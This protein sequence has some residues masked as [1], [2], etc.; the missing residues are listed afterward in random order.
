MSESFQVVPS[1]AALAAE[2]RGLD[3][4]QALSASTVAAV[5]RALIDTR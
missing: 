3:L 2:V 4:S 1:G 5:R